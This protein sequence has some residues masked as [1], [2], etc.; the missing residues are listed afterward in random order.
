MNRSLFYILPS[1]SES[2]VP[3]FIID[4]T[5]VFITLCH[6]STQA[7]SES[8]FSSS[9]SFRWRSNKICEQNKNENNN[10]THF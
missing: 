1:I 2:V 5:K 7:A 9:L 4:I 8:H 10:T 3:V 6:I